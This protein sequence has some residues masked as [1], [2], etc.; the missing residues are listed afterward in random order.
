M[1]LNGVKVW[2]LF[3]L[4][5]APRKVEFLALYLRQKKVIWREKG[6]LYRRADGVVPET[7]QTSSKWYVQVFHFAGS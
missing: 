1:A 4:C 3:S 6:W 7:G 5:S 2:W